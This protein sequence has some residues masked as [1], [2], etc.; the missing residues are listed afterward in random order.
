LLTLLAAFLNCR[1]MEL[2]D[3]LV[4]LLIATVHRI[5]LQLVG[6]AVGAGTAV[7]DHMFCHMGSVPLTPDIRF[8]THPVLGGVLGTIAHEE[9]TPP[10]DQN[11]GVPKTGVFGNREALHQPEIKRR[12][13]LVTR[14]LPTPPMARRR[15]AT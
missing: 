6:L 10:E 3:T 11:K 13:R 9:A 1:E 4:E 5:E 8:G 15:R 2:T 12:L 14:S 7:A